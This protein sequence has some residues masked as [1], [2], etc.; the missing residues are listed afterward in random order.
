MSD[1]ATED[2][3][4]VT[5]ETERLRLRRLTACDAPFIL[6]L[7]NEPSFIKHI[8]DRGVRTEADAVGYIEKG[9]AASWEKNG[10]GLDLVELKDTGEPLGICGL[11]R[12]E[13]LPEVDVGYAFLPEHWSK[14]YALESVR[15]AMAHA[16]DTLGLKRV[17]AIVNADNDSS[18]RL[19]EKLGFR[20]ERKM[21][22]PGEDTEVKVYVS[23]P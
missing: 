3:P 20:Y 17:L 6:R 8:G 19:L 16:R 18:I 5:L 9:P 7:V 10:F 21:K 1:G 13:I 15:G 12:R 22:M 23:D 11:I 14:G 4:Q 2:T